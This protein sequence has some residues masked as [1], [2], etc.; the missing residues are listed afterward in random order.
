MIV[1]RKPGNDYLC[2]WTS[3]YIEKRIKTYN[4]YFP[5]NWMDHLDVPDR[6][7]YYVEFMGI[8]TF[9]IYKLEEYVNSEYVDK[10]RH[11]DVALMVHCTGHGYHEI[12]EEVYLNIVIRDKVPVD[13]IILSSESFDLYSAVQ[14]AANKHNLPPIR[15]RVAFEFEAY[16]NHWINGYDDRINPTKLEYKNYDKKYVSLNGYFRDHRAAIVFGLASYNL[17]DKG[18]VSYSIKDGGSKGYD[19]YE[20]L[21]N[22]L[23]SCPEFVQ[24]L[25]DNEEQLVKL[26][27][28][29]LDTD[30]NQQGRNLAQPEIQ[31]TEFFNNT[32]FTLLTET[33]FPDMRRT[34]YTYCPDIL[35][36]NI[37]R[38]Y[39]EK[40]FRCI[41]FKHPFIATGPKGFLEVLRWLGYKTFHPIIDESYDQEPDHAKRLWMIVQETRRLCELEGDA[42]KNF[43]DQAREICEYNYNVLKNR[44][45]FSFD[46]PIDTNYYR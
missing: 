19:A 23:R 18:Y 24:L 8:D 35:S 39:S 36:D 26:D 13:N 40:T 28:I 4:T 41:A 9:K 37:G 2:L 10:I 43:L 30:Y 5:Q 17:I 6:K 33:N 1:N 3:G 34:E 31:H 20:N 14:W 15:T 21:V 46:L 22:R 7:I 11:G 45:I 16:A 29:L 42:L 27:H 38:L 12:A 25:V 44:K 32:Y